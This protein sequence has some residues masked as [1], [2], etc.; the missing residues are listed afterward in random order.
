[1]T[2][3]NSMDAELLARS[4]LDVHE[5]QHVFSVL[6][7][8]LSRPGEILRLEASLSARINVGLLPLL[9]LAGHRTPFAV[10]GLDETNE[11]TAVALTT[12]GIRVSAAEADFVALTSPTDAGRVRAVLADVR[13]GTDATPHT[14]AQVSITWPGSLR[15][16]PAG[17]GGLR[18]RFRGPGIKEHVIVSLDCTDE[19]VTA[20]VEARASVF[21]LG[22]DVWLIDEAGQVIGI[23]RT[24][25]I[26]IVDETEP[27]YQARRI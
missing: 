3:Q 25:V 4:A 15:N 21:P 22:F 11:A 5:S 6:M 18:L 10:I 12:G 26:T 8:A 1:M 16:G 14:A 20:L 2:H 19:L 13:T 17:A 24:T 27:E 7:S 9:A 23:P